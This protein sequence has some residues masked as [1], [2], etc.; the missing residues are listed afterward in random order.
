[1]AAH[2]QSEIEIPAAGSESDFRLTDAFL[3]KKL[4]MGRMKG[5][6]GGEEGRGRQSET[7]KWFWAQ[8]A[9]CQAAAAD[10]A[11]VQVSSR[12]TVEFACM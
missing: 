2:A 10:S 12:P 9:G 11:S 1:M 6:R 8:D 7:E 5:G 4:D 3:V